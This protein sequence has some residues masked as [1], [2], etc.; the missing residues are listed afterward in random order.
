[1]NPIVHGMLAWIFAA[2]AIRNLHDR[3]LVVIAGVIPDIDAIL[4]F[5][6]EDLFYEYHHTLGHSYVFAIPLAVL[7]GLA[8]R[9]RSRVFL[10]T[11]G[12]FTLHLVADYFGSNW[13]IQFL[14]PFSDYELTSSEYLSYHTIYEVIN[15]IIAVIS[16]IIVLIIVY[17]K[18]FSPFEFISPNLDKKLVGLYIYP[19]KYSCAICGSRAFISCEVC[20]EKVCPEHIG[21][22]KKWVCSDCRP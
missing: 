3:R 8:A 17:G 12:V 20:R 6:S 7:F 14:Y 21:S 4:L 1:M 10:G 18:E 15:P 16:I 22:F 13:S 2:L 11:I 9:S 19:L 5:V